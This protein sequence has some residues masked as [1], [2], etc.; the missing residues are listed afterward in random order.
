M[1][2]NLITKKLFKQLDYIT[3]ITA[4]IIVLF[5]SANIYSATY[6]N[7]GFYYCM[8]QIIWLLIGLILVFIIIFIDYK[9]IM[10][11][12]YLIYWV[13]AVL[14][15]YTDFATK[16]VKG[17]NSWIK[18]GGFSFQPGEFAKIGLIIILAKK[19]DDMEGDVNNPKNFFILCL[20]ALIPMA[21]LIKQPNLGMAL[22]CFFIALGMLYISGLDLKI[23]FGGAIV[24]IPF[25][26]LIWFSGLLKVYQKNR[27]IAFL[28]PGTYQQDIGFQLTQSIIG[29]GSGGIFGTGFLN[30]NQSV[31]GFV[32][33][34][35]TDFIFSVVAEEWGFIGAI[36]L[37]A[38][39]GILLYRIIKLAKSSESITGRLICVGT[40]ASF[41]FSILQNI[42]M[43]IGIM[44]IAG[45]T[46]PFMSYGGSSIIT[47]FIYLGL[48]L[49]VGMRRN[50][51]NF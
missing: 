6:A 1:I 9:R 7:Y 13:G 36:A 3:L 51:I 18:I 23:I 45:I 42:G 49:N 35:H 43:T 46:L 47:N 41:L 30:G 5:G 31:S 50:K 14:V 28:D 4:V 48:V 16:A 19:I 27:I 37:L 32:P 24:M 26:L 40:V 2:N 21:L 38:L 11:H 17:A 10:N 12:S 22:I 20:Y 8:S 29:I 34:A 33:E 15:L 44:P 25:S 39:Y